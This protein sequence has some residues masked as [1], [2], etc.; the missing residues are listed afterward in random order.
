MNRA[1]N[2]TGGWPFAAGEMARRV[3]M[4]DWAS[5]PLGPVERWSANLRTTVQLVLEHAFATIVLWGPDLIQIYNDRYRQLMGAK[6]PAGL[7]QPTRECWP[8]IWHINAPIYE[9][10]WRGE[11]VSFDDAHYPIRRFGV[12]EDAWFTLSYSP[13]RDET[14]AVAGVL[15]TIIEATRRVRAEQAVRDSEAQVRHTAELLEQLLES[16]PDPI[17]TNDLEGRITALN[18]AAAAVLGRPREALMGLRNSEALPAAAL[19]AVEMEDRRILQGEQT[20]RVEQTLFDANR[21]E[22]RV[23][24]TVKAPLRSPDGLVTGIVGIARDITEHKRVEEALRASE[25]FNRRVLQSSPDC[26][27]VLSLDARL[28]FFSDGGL[29]IMEVDDF[30]RQLRGVEW[31]SLWRPEDQPQVLAAIDMAMAGNV[32]R[33]Q[34]FCYTAKG[35]PKWWDVSVTAIRGP[36]GLPHRLLSIS[37]DITEQKAAEARLAELNATLEQQVRQ[38]TAK[39]RALLDSAGTAIVAT[40]LAGRI[41]IFNPA[42]EQ[43][44][45]IPAA[46]AVGRLMLDFHDLDEVQTNGNKIPSVMRDH[47]H[48]QP[49]LVKRALRNSWASELAQPEVQTEWTYV[50]ADGTRFPG[51]LSMSLLRHE[52]DTPVGFMGV[53]TDLTERK[54]M[55]RALRQRTADLEA[56]TARERAIFASA[57]TGIMITDLANNIIALNPAAQRML[58]I[59]QAQAQGR[60]VLSFHDLDEVRQ[61]LHVIPTEVRGLAT[62][63]SEILPDDQKHAAPQDPATGEQTEWTFVRADGSRFPALLNMSV[64]RDTQGA[65]LG[66][67]G[68]VTD[69]TERKALE[70]QLRERTRQAEAATAAKSVFL[71]H[72]SHE[73][74]TPLNAVIGLSQLLVQTNLDERQ[75]MFVTH[76]NAAGEHLLSVVNDILDVSKIEA[77]EMQLEAAPFELSSLLQSARAIV[78]MQAAQKR[79]RLEL[80][81][82]P[83]LPQRLVGDVTR[84]KQILANLL[85]NAVKF[86][87]AGVVT[88]RVMHL[89]LEEQERDDPR[90]T[91]AALRIEISDTGIGIPREKQA[92]IFQPFMQADATTTR[93]FGG[94]GLGLSIVRR[95]VEL[96]GGC[97]DVRSE[98]GQGSTFSFTVKLLVVE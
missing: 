68:I 74:R 12:I 26:L 97:L 20:I 34:A 95:L 10:V 6:H 22:P 2:E 17:W 64:L 94:T 61:R 30:E 88:L 55:E 78:E 81:L 25:E 18:S 7:G 9:R 42:A 91:L 85:G 54:A 53:I 21:G 13:V 46:Q 87:D 58:R 8:E 4:H 48:A 39:L 86:T 16:A 83:A 45:R 44:F 62:G 82:D 70:Q 57:A 36:D 73:I 37:R 96:M 56:I 38:Q 51:L 63:L 60:P 40:D 5:T 84:L 14:G 67:L 79:L 11:S 75:R 33:F 90:P 65:P 47:G 41:T 49:D 76:V 35:T 50:R 19:A 89:M 43:L 71:A 52:P 93:R 98:P 80:E 29:C 72:M 28:E 69:V 66:F 15:L 3:R 59:S 77:G 23:F 31:V 32:G 24:F 27:K 1:D 92:V